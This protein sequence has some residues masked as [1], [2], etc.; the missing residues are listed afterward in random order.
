MK[1]RGFKIKK[2]FLGFKKFFKNF[3][4]DKNCFNLKTFYRKKNLNKT[5]F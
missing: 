4:K 1:G 3:P 2:N 5:N